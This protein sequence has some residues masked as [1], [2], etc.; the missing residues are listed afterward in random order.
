MGDCVGECHRKREIP[1]VRSPICLIP[2][3]PPGVHYQPGCRCWALLMELA[4]ALV[5]ELSGK[6]AAMGSGLNH[7][8]L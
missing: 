7:Y 6:D 2:D 3:P 4:N 1:V 5:T 8:P